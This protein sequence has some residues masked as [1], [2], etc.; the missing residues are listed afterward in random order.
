[1]VSH[2]NCHVYAFMY[3]DLCARAV[4]LFTFMCGEKSKP[5]RKMPVCFQ[6]L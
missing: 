5:K 4:V 2:L 3:V 1:M 6:L